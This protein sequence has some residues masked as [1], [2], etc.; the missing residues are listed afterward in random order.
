MCRYLR[1]LV[2]RKEKSI[3]HIVSAIW[4]GLK[5]KFWHLL[6]TDIYT[7][8]SPFNVRKEVG[9]ISVSDARGVFKACYRDLSANLLDRSDHRDSSPFEPTSID[10]ES[11]G[12]DNIGELPLTASVHSE[13]E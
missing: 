3:L 1:G 13:S 9:F 12:I 4:H 10:K 7:Q 2:C 6:L 5:T 8:G 11:P